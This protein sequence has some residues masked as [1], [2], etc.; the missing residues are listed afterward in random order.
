MTYRLRKTQEKNVYPV[1]EI[2]KC[3]HYT[4]TS[5]IPNWDCATLRVQ[6]YFPFTVRI[7]MNGRQW[8]YQQLRQRKVAFEHQGKLLLSVADVPLAQ[9]LLDTQV[10][11]DYVQ[12][13][14]ELVQP[15]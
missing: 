9:E 10:H 4:T 14:S 7:G 8:L 1:K 6:S 5:S 3:L 15:I 13:L 12:I 2:G 11:A